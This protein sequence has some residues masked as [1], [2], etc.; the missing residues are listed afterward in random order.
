MLMAMS[1][2]HEGNIEN[3]L[4]DDDYEG[5]KYRMSVSSLHLSALDLITNKL[6]QTQAKKHRDLINNKYVFGKFIWFST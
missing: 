2:I 3:L 5:N 1:M 6:D 4:D